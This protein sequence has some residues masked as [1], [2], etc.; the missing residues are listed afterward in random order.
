MQALSEVSP[1]PLF[2]L[3]CPEVLS[4]CPAGGA[5]PKKDQPEMPKNHPTDAADFQPD[6]VKLTLNLNPVVDV[7]FE[8]SPD[9]LRSAL[10]HGR[11]E[12]G[13]ALPFWLSW[14]TERSQKSA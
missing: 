9:A 3:A 6:T 8:R 11:L 12:V 1:E 13:N 7:E 4:A 14:R 10:A 5:Q 2:P